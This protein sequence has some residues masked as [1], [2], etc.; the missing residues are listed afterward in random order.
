MIRIILSKGEEYL[1]L[2]LTTQ[3]S[4]EV[5][6]RYE[7]EQLLKG[8]LEK[9]YASKGSDLTQTDD[10]LN[11]AVQNGYAKAVVHLLKQ[12]ADVNAKDHRGRT[13]HITA[14]KNGTWDIFDLM[15]N[16]KASINERDSD[17][18]TA[19]MFAVSRGNLDAVKRLINLGVDI[20]AKDHNGN[21][22]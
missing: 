11:M 18:W 1:G 8:I 17:G 3:E 2:N 5:A 16:A 19:L 4:V 13:P 15:L 21:T 14:A 7:K 22:P 20:Y 9:H 12:K 10:A 6:V